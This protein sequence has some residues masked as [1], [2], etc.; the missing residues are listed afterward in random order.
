MGKTYKSVQ[1]F[2][3]DAFGSYREVWTSLLVNF[4]LLLVKLRRQSR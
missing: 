2:I 3:G 4:S 1:Q